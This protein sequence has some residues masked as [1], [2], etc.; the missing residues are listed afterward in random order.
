M[1]AKS[2]EDMRC[3]KAKSI[4]LLPLNTISASF[5]YLMFIEIQS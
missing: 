4:V 1:E 5:V 3:L 2:K